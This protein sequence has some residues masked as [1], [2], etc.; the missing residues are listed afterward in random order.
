MKLIG[1]DLNVVVNKTSNSDCANSSNPREIE[2][3]FEGRKAKVCQVGEKFYAKL[4]ECNVEDKI[5]T[6]KANQSNE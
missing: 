6:K 1:R 3:K 4:S 5:D 2:L